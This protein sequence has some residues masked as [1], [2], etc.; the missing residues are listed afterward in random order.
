MASWYRLTPKEGELVSEKVIRYS[1]AF[2]RQVVSELAE[3]RYGS[4]YEASE[5]YGI[6]GRETVSRWVR[7][8]GREEVLKKVVRVEKPGEL[9]EVKR[10]KE[11]VRQLESALADAHID[12]ALAEAYFEVLCESTGVDAEAFK[13]KHVGIVSTGRGRSSRRG[14]K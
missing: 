6:R 3:G 2:K 5:A 9:R 11:R 13:K 4:P 12:G 7:Q 10:L 8:Y 1:E 14:G